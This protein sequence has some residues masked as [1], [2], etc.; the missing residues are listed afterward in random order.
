MPKLYSKTGDKGLTSLYD[1][2]KVEKCDF[3]F[4]LLGSV[5]ELSS[6]IGML[7]S[8]IEEF[9]NQER[10]YNYC[11]YLQ[12]RLLDLGSDIAT[13]KSRKQINSLNQDDINEIEKEIDHYS[14]LVPE[15][16]EFILPGTNIRDSQAHICRSVTR[17]VERNLWKFK[18]DHSHLSIESFIFI[19]R[20]SDYFFAVAR[21]LSDKEIKRKDFVKVNKANK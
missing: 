20:L 11:R 21:F 13:I 10:A 6:H 14:S 3:I 18:K 1:M 15:L 7:A 12:S 5:D 9:G 2:S 16:K 4:D 8:L 17:N 19:N